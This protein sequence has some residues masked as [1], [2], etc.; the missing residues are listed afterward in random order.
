MKVKFT[1]EMSIGLMTIVG[2]VLLYIGV[3]FLKGINLF[4]PV[5]HYYVSCSNVKDVTI[6]TPVYVDGFKVGLVRSIAYDYSTTGKLTIEINLEKSM[7]INKGSYVSIEKTLLSGGELHIHLNTYLDEYLKSGDFIESRMP[8]DMMATVQEKMLPQIV[9]LLPKLD[10][11]LYGLQL[12]VNHPGIGQTLNNLQ[13]TTS[14]LEVTSKHLNQLL[15]KDVPVIATNLKKTTDNFVVLSEDLKQMELPE[16]VKSL[17][18]TLGNLQ[19]TTNR[20]NTTDNS[21]G[22]LMNDSLLYN[23]LNR[24]VGNASDLLID[25]KQNPKRYIRFSVF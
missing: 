22:L 13:A 20:L 23:N 19:Q 8:D 14:N 4:R 2:L 16:T 9:E 15:Q 21:L 3:N 25:F 6:S 1:K 5:N 24:T 10:S 11:I 18:A 12:L 17:N 7:R